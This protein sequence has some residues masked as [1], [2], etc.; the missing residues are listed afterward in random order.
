MLSVCKNQRD[1][2]IIAILDQ[3]GCRAE[4]LRMTRI[5]DVVPD[6]SRHFTTINLGKGKTGRRRIVIT[7]GIGDIQA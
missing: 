6:E 4:E 2:A 5:G 1:R 3:T 7:E